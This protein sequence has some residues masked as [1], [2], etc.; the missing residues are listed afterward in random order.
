[1]AVILVFLWHSMGQGSCQRSSVTVTIISGTMQPHHF[2]LRGVLTKGACV[3][4]HTW[5]MVI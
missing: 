4:Q 5:E 3:R 2:I 1:M